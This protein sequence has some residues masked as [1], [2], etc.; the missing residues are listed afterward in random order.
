[1][2][3]Q[4]NIDNSTGCSPLKVTTQPLLTLNPSPQGEGLQSRREKGAGNEGRFDSVDV[5]VSYRAG[6][7]HAP[8]RAN[9]L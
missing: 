9:T 8:Y 4:S 2:R 1:M 7:G 6:V 5:P 3:P